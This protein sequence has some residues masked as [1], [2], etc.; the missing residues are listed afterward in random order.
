MCGRF[1]AN[2]IDVVAPLILYLYLKKITLEYLLEHNGHN[3]SLDLHYT[4]LFF[5]AFSGNYIVCLRISI[6]LLLQNINTTR[7]ARFSDA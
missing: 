1:H 7:L 6:C 5:G 4:I 2:A 3:Q